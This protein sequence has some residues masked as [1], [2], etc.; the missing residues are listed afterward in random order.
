MAHGRS[1][2]NLA[3]CPSCNLTSLKC[4]SSEWS[5]VLFISF[6]GDCQALAVNCRFP[7]PIASPNLPDAPAPAAFNIEVDANSCFLELPLAVGTVDM[8]CRYCTLAIEG[9]NGV[10]STHFRTLLS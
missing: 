1:Q 10:V 6:I 5:V 8:A 2:Y 7:P 9:G 3:F 4:P